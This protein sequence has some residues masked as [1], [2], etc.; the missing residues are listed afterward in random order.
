MKFGTDFLY[1]TS[2]DLEF[3]ENSLVDSN[4]W[5]SGVNETLRVFSLF[6]DRYE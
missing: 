3:R 1:K 5:V 4:V 6:L 2:M